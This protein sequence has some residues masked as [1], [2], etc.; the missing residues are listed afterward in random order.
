MPISKK[1][2]VKKASLHKRSSVNASVNT[3]ESWQAQ[4]VRW[5]DLAGSNAELAR[6]LGCPKR[7]VE[8]WGYGRQAPAPWVQDLVASVIPLKLGH[9]GR[10]K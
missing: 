8:A 9:L 4:V 5:R 10:V 2:P 1:Q 6:V 7:T 3:S